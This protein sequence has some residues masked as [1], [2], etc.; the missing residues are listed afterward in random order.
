[1]EPTDLPAVLPK[2]PIT[3]QQFNEV[4]NLIA[5]SSNGTQNVLNQLHISYNSLTAYINTVGVEAQLKYARAKSEQA[6][7]LADEMMAIADESYPPGDSAAVNDKRLRIDTRKW[8]ASKL[9][10]KKYGDNL[11]IDHRG[12]AQLPNRIE[13]LMVQPTVNIQHNNEQISG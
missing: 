1:V 7:I 6:D 4:C 5:N 8:I 9:K 2:T 11:T 13:V 12:D 3:D 10:P